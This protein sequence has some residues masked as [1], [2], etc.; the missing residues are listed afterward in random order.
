MRSACEW[1][2]A[3]AERDGRI[4]GEFTLIVG[5]LDEKAISARMKGEAEGAWEAAALELVT[6][7]ASGRGVATSTIAKDVSARFGVPKVGA[8]PLLSPST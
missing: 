1:Y 7:V 6:L 2:A 4:R 3:V 8:D 5:P